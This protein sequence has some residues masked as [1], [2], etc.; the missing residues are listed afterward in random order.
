MFFTKK[1]ENIL[2]RFLASFVA[3]EECAT[4]S[5]LELLLSEFDTTQRKIIKKF[6]AQLATFRDC[7]PRSKSTCNGSNGG[8]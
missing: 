5:Q 2:I 6:L 7:I 1:R 8:E 3:I 4:A